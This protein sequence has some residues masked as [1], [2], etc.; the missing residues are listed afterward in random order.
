MAPDQP[1]TCVPAHQPL[2]LVRPRELHFSKEMLSHQEPHREG[3]SIPCENEVQV[4]KISPFTHS[5]IRRYDQGSYHGPSVVTGI[6]I[7][8]ILQEHIH[9]MPGKKGHSENRYLLS[10]TSTEHG[11]C[12]RH[13][14]RCSVKC[15][16]LHLNDKSKAHSVTTTRPPGHQNGHLLT[17]STATDRSQDL[18]DFL[19]S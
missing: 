11:L 7:Q 19:R 3:W 6:R 9:I 1:G 8:P 10:S 12:A 13:C 5:V 15:P 2:S 17:I 16:G 14:I 18:K 4:Q